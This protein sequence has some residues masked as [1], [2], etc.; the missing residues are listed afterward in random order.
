L[1]AAPRSGPEIAAFSACVRGRVQG[2][3]FR[4]TCLHEARLQGIRG[5]VRNTSE[6]DVEVW[7]EAP[8][9]KLDAFLQ[10]LRR[11]PPHA[12]V[13]AV[14]YTLQAPTGAYKDFGVTY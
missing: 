7:A 5:W 6:G 12:R 4:Y 2:V 13:D 3:G 8:K 10:W 14:D 9:G 11:G 1:K